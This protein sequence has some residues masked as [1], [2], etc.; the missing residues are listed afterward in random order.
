MGPRGPP[1]KEL[2]VPNKLSPVIGVVDDTGAV[3]GLVHEGVPNSPMTPLGAVTANSIA[4]ALETAVVGDPTSV[5]RVQGLVSGGAA[6]AFP[7]TLDALPTPL[8]MAHRSGAAVYPQSTI[9]G[10][11]ATLREGNILLEMDV[12]KTSDGVL[13]V[14]HDDTVDSLTDGT[15]SIESKTWAEV[16]ALNIDI[17]PAYF[18]LAWPAALK[19]PAFSEVLERYKGVAVFIV[20]D[21]NPTA[22]I[23]AVMAAISAAGVPPRQVLLQRG[24]DGIAHLT[25]AASAGYGCMMLTTNGSEL[26]AATLA[27]AGVRYVGAD[28][29]AFPQAKYNEMTAAGITP[30]IYTI[31]RRFQLANVLARGGGG[32]FSDDPTYTSRKAA[33]TTLS[34]YHTQRMSS[35]MIGALSETQ[36]T[37]DPTYRGVFMPPNYFGWDTTQGSYRGC[38]QGNLSPVANPSNFTLDFRITFIAVNNASRWGSVFFGDGDNS[39][40]DDTGSAQGNHLLLRQNGTLAVYTKASGGGAVLVTSGAAPAFT[41]DTEYNIRV[42]VSSTTIV[43]AVVDDTGT[44]TFS[45]TAATSTYRGGYLTLGR[46]G[47]A[48]KYRMLR[49]TSV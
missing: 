19:I 29:A 4:N 36:D 39:F 11:D 14:F 48:V 27:A 33:T 7:P 23:P 3:V 30:V 26:S 46:N 37:T 28:Y 2:S 34:Q 15:G 5:S 22:N 16:R 32:V 40:L 42:M 41:L 25:A 12:R 47:A 44:P 9:E 43:V 13:V 24:M 38:L 10:Y 8:V 20:E 35:G 18:G 21:K 49:V 45:V 6:R 31:S 1:S 17:G